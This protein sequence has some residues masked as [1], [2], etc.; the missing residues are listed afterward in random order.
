METPVGP[1]PSKR[2]S[3][4]SASYLTSANVKKNLSVTKQA[5]QYQTIMDEQCS[6]CFLLKNATDLQH[7]DAYIHKLI[8][9]ITWQDVN[10]PNG[11]PF[12]RKT[13]WFTAG[14]CN[15]QYTHSG[16]TFD[17]IEY[18][19]WLTELTDKVHESLCSA[20]V[21]AE[22]PNCCNVNFYESGDQSLGW[23]ADDEPL[24]AIDEE[25]TFISSLSLGAA[26]G[27][28]I[29]SNAFQAQAT[30]VNLEHGDIFTMSG[31]FQLDFK[32]SLPKAGPNLGPRLNLTWRSIKHHCEACFKSA[33]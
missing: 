6:N 12:P 10:K 11:A 9:Q 31:R 23:H 32:H 27:F 13:A 16:V 29:K 33:S 19:Q 15:C 2:G 18:P 8:S 1:S 28:A 7:N 24:F 22:Y 25:E 5:A 14:E 26:R 17:A 30:T 4:D 20:G 21:A 3:I